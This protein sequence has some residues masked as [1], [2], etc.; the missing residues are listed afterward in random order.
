MTGGEPESRKR[1]LGLKGHFKTCFRLH[2]MYFGQ[3]KDEADALL[4]GNGW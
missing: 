4:H 2:H 3:T 1:R